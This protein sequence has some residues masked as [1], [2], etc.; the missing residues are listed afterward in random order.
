MGTTEKLAQF[1]V[2]TGYENIPAPAVHAAKRAII[3]TLG[4]ML[5]GS[6]EAAGKVITSFVRSLGGEPRAWVVGAGFRTSSP[7]AALANGTMAHAI[8]YD[9]VGLFGKPTGSVL[10][11]VLALGEDLKASGQAVLE[12]LILGIEIGSKL[13]LGTNTRAMG[14]HPTAVF[15]TM[16]TAAAA[17]KL[18]GLDIEQTRMVL[19][20][21]SSHAIGM[22]RNRGTM[23]K[24]YHQG[25]AAQS[26]VVSAM[27]VKEGFTA[28]PDLIEG[29]VGF[30]NAFGGDDGNDSKVTDNLGNPY[31]IISP[32]IAVK[33]YP[34]CYVTHRAI[35]AM[36]Q[37]QDKHQISPDDVAEI[38]CQAG[39]TVASILVYNEPVNYLQA[40]FSM[41][42]CLATALV[43]RKVGLLEVTNEKVNDPKIK[44]L[45][46]R[47]RL[48]LGD[49]PS[50][51]RDIV[52]V[53]LKD[54][55][56]YSLGVDRARGSAEIPL[57]DEEIISKYRDCAGIIMP[58][59]K[60][61]QALEL[62]LNLEQLRQISEL[63][64]IV[65]GSKIR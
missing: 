3:D 32:G 18:L 30:Y 25:K 2:E 20:L 38:E 51:Q 54:G 33:K 62:M 19:G 59:D 36:L 12:A 13:S 58:K 14:F 6:Q 5:V 40:K 28:A 4:V 11:T 44:Q 34:A 47:V 7:N 53:R 61:E 26:G 27:L 8:D 41:Q 37:L 31:S 35:D 1:I 9:D 29:R 39:S 45:M 57:T 49:E 55:K 48:N 63:M 21:A 56:E 52:T 16:G 10:P 50:T 23:T 24:P 15:G 17:A 65:S 42:F 64:D 22:S 46:K 60:V 43:E